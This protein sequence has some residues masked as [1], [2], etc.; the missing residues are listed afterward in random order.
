VLFSPVPGLS[1]GASYLWGRRRDAD[2]QA[3]TD[4]RLQLS[5]RYSFSTRIK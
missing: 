3:G 4:N 2:S 5:V 1:L